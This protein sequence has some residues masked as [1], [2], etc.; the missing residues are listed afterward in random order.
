MKI[1]LFC[2]SIFQLKL[3]NYYKKN[4]DETNALFDNININTLK[5]IKEISEQKLKNEQKIFDFC[6]NIIECNSLDFKFDL[7][8]KMFLNDDNLLN[9]KN[10]KKLIT[11]KNLSNCVGF[12]CI[13]HIMRKQILILY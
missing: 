9:F 2:S 13:K 4:V 10:P 3:D 6:F 1:H 11:E 8:K 12:T 7:I 5:K